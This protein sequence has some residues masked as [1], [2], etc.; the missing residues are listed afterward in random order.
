MMADILA[1]NNA[2]SACSYD[3]G[4]QGAGMSY[5]LREDCRSVADPQRFPRNRLLFFQKP[6][7]IYVIQR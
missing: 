4:L 5:V 2:A 3:H 6:F 1:S 7:T